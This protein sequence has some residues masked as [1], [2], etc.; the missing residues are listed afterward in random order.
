[1]ILKNNIFWINILGGGIDSEGG[2]LV[3]QLDVPSRPNG[4]IAN[5]GYL[6]LQIWEGRDG[7]GR[8]SNCYCKCPF[9]GDFLPPGCPMS[10]E[11]DM[12]LILH[13]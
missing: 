2:D 10:S 7:G 6:L 11:Y 3:D 8:M 4:N 1:M 9:D 12:C 13:L 5:I